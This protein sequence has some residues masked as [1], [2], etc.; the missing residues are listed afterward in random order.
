VIRREG[1]PAP[2]A[3]NPEVRL[4]LLPP[5]RS[6]L[7]VARRAE[8]GGFPGGGEAASRKFYYIGSEDIAS[9]GEFVYNTL[10]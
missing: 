6:L 9:S 1:I 8:S 5:G 7:Y 10:P 2:P 4:L 3:Q